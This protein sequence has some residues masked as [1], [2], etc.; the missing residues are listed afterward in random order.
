M[1]HAGK[2]TSDYVDIL[3]GNF[4]ELVPLLSNTETNGE[5]GYTPVTSEDPIALAGVTISTT[6][7]FD[8]GSV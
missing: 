4:A 5:D 8:F 7:L 3:D 1:I 2:L 6:G